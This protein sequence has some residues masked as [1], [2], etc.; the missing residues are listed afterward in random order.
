MTLNILGQK[1]T[2]YLVDPDL[3]DGD[4]GEAKHE[5]GEIWIR[6]DIHDPDKFNQVLFHEITHWILYRNGLAEKLDEVLQ[7]AICDTVGF[8]MSENLDKFYEE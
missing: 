6:N 8:V 7:E 3:I 2:V 4:K 1:V 5:I